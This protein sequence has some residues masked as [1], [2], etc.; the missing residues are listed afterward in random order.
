MINTNNVIAITSVNNV[1]VIRNAL[2]LR[3]RKVVIHIH[4]IE[5]LETVMN[6]TEILCGYTNGRHGIVL[7]LERSTCIAMIENILEHHEKT[8]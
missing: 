4:A 1:T 6:R 5:E 3:R 8:P 7:S 2:N